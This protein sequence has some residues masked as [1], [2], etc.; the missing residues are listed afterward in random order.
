MT[1]HTPTTTGDH[2]PRTRT[3]SLH[4]ESAFRDGW[5]RPSTSPI[6]P[7]QKA[8]S[9]SRTTPPAALNEGPRLGATGSQLEAHLADVD[10]ARRHV[11]LDR[12]VHP[13]HRRQ[14]RFDDPLT[15]QRVRQPR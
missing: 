10:P 12:E 3:G 8:L 13:L 4:L 9:R 11:V 1:D 15:E 14:D 6:V 7:D 2:Q 5:M